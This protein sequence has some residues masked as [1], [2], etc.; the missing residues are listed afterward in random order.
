MPMT[1]PSAATTGP[2]S[3]PRAM[4]RSYASCTLSSDVNVRT[5]VVMTSLTSVASGTR[6]TYRREHDGQALDEVGRDEPALRSGLGGEAVDVGGPRR[7]LERYNTLGQERGDDA[8]EHVT[9]AGGR[10]PG[11]TLGGDEHAPVR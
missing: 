9:R 2:P 4:S 8:R 5:S 6:S 10:E 11:V 1:L 3:I 7:G